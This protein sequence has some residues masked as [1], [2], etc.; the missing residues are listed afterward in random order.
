MKETSLPCAVVRDLLPSYLE[1]L[2]EEETGRLV[3]EHLTCCADCSGRYKTMKEP[4]PEQTIE[5]HQVDY[6]KTIRRRSRKHMILAVV[7]VCIL[8]ISGISAKLFWIGSPIHMDELSYQTE[9]LESA[10][11]LYVDCSLTDSASNFGNWD[12]RLDQE[13]GVVTLDTRKVLISPF[14]SKEET[15]LDLPLEGVHTVILL[16]E[17]I[18]QDGLSID[19]RTNAMYHAR[20]PYVG[21][22]SSL[23]TLARTMNLPKV[24]FT[25][26]LQTT[27]E[28]YGWTLRFESPLYPQ[29]EKQMQRIAPLFLALVDNLGEFR[30]TCPDINGGAPV[31]HMVT[32]DEINAQLP[33]LVAQYNEQN[34]TEWVALDSVKE[35]SEHVFSLQQLVLLLGV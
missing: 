16:G 27:T 34:G 33:E 26:E 30:W 23:H 29:D 14:S 6:L 28:P 22:A 5:A 25:N 24:S 15:S 20:T 32:L 18:W 3:Q 11:L 2:T 10:D 21:N 35:Y 4:E 31:E 17:T 12:I 9:Y 7:L 13:H 8:T 19:A 1:G